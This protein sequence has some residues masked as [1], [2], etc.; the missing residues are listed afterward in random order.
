MGNEFLK[1]KGKRV[2]ITRPKHQ[3]KEMIVKL[4]KAG[5]KVIHIPLIEI[6]DPSDNFKSLDRAISRLETYDWLI[7]TSQNSVS[8]FFERLSLRGARA[9]KQSRFAAVGPATAAALKKRGIRK[10]IV[11]RKNDY[12]AAGLVNVLKRYDFKDKRVLFPCAKKAKE[13]LPIWLKKQG[14]KLDKVEAYQTV[15]P[16]N[17]NR[18]GLRKLIAENKIDEVIFFSRSAKENF[19]K[20]TGRKIAK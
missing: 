2:L 20:I 3:A 7:F 9:T 15:M 1:L 14:A 10:V 8:K 6:A 5:A 13:I 11:P 12:S 19:T 16:K 18:A 4:R 17:L